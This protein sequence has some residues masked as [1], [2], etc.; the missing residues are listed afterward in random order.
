MLKN[1]RR[2]CE[3]SSYALACGLYRLAKKTLL[4]TAIP[5]WKYRFSSDHR[6]QAT[7]GSVSTWMGD[8]LGIPSAVDFYL[9]FL[10]T[11]WTYLTKLYLRWYSVFIIIYFHLFIIF[12]PDKSLLLPYLMYFCQRNI[13]VFSSYPIVIKRLIICIHPCTQAVTETDITPYSKQH[14]IHLLIITITDNKEFKYL[15][16]TAQS[17][18]WTSNLN[19]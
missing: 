16:R 8:R 1:V 15:F 10:I 2:F 4:S 17:Q 13:P 9:N 11:N 18:G 6:S 12:F 5:R 14:N 19:D 3:H 7:S